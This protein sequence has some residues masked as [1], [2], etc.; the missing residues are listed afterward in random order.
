MTRNASERDTSGREWLRS[1][2]VLAGFREALRGLPPDYDARPTVLAGSRYELGRQLAIYLRAEG[3]I[4]R[5]PTPPCLRNLLRMA[6]NTG[7]PRIRGLN[8]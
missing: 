4:G 5:R 1:P 2:D 7:L 3:L 6:A 8:A